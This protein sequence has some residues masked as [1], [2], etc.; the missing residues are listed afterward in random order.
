MTLIAMWGTHW[1]R[2]NRRVRS[3]R[4]INSAPSGDDR[5]ADKEENDK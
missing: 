1:R 4:K 5:I 3:V 2:W